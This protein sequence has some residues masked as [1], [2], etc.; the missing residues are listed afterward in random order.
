MVPWKQYGFDYCG[1]YLIGPQ[2][3][4]PLKVGISESAYKRIDALQTAHWQQIDCHAYWICENKRAAA[5]V[6]RKAHALL[7]D[8]PR[9]MMGEWFDIDIN[10]AREIVVFAAQSVGVEIV[11]DL[12]RVDKFKK[13]FAYLEVAA[14]RWRVRFC[15]AVDRKLD[16]KWARGR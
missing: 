10:K 5:L 9:H 15:D 14:P 12:P 6:E 2:K 1:V 4:W 11:S 16:E 7:K 8:G 13:V 3:R